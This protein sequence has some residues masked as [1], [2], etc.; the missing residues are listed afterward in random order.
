MVYIHGGGF[1]AGSP[2]SLFHGPQYFMDNGEVILVLMAYRLGALG[3]LATGD[4]H[5]PGNFGLKDQTLALKWVKDNIREFG[6]N[7]NSVTVFGT[8]A[9]GTSA[10]MHMISPLSKGNILNHHGVGVFMKQTSVAS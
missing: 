6:G 9:G 10:H 8:S 2:S 4:E 7:P 5:S 1:F 3:F